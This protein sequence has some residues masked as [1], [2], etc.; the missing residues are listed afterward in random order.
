MSESAAVAT[1]L[2]RVKDLQPRAHVQRLEDKFSVGIP[3]MNICYAYGERWIEAKW[4]A[5]WPKRES[6]GVRVPFKIEQ[7]LW[8]K[9]R[10]EAGGDVR[11]L[12]R[13]GSKYW[14]CH[15][16]KDV[17]FTQLLNGAYNRKQFLDLAHWHGTTMDA[18]EVLK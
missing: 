13:V 4:I 10:F 17:D 8:A 11:V 7:P 1:F 2:A 9:Q 5:D 12:L 16:F 18:R 3:D 14:T 15:R 6:T